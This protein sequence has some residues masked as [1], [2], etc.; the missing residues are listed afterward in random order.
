MIFSSEDSPRILPLPLKKKWFDL[1]I[2]GKKKVE[3]REQ[4]P[5]VTSRLKNLKKDYDLIKFI[6]GYAGDKPY[7][8]CEYKGF[9]IS[10]KFE[11]L[12]F[13]NLKIDV[14]KGDYVIKLGKIIEKGNV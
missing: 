14:K 1:M 6:N 7:F 8:I 11:T 12:H 3:I 2:S 13:E 10:N 9:E 4:K 5:W